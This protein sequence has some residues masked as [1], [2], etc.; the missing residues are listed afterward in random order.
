MLDVEFVVFY[1]CVPEMGTSCI[2]SRVA[3]DYERTETFSWL[4]SAPRTLDAT[5]TYLT[6]SPVQIKPFICLIKL[7]LN[8]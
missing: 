5:K 7:Q 3:Q 6:F 8:D 1:V 4:Q 2:I